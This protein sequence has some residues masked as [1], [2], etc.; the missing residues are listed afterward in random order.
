MNAKEAK[1]RALWQRLPAIV[2]DDIEFA[3][4][5]G[6]LEVVRYL[7]S[8][9]SSDIIKNIRDTLEELG[10]TVEDKN[11]AFTNKLEPIRSNYDG[12]YK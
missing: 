5:Q 9:V 10:Y 1:E 8:N 6:D 4:N 3:I 11:N 12:S 7:P 2:K